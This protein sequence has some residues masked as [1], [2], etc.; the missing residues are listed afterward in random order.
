[1][2]LAVLSPSPTDGSGW[3]RAGG[4]F[5]PL[6]KQHGFQLTTGEM[7]SW[8]KIM[9]CD[10]LFMQRPHDESHFLVAGMARDLKVPIWIDYDDDLTHIPVSNLAHDAYMT[11]KTFRNMKAIIEMAQVAT[12]STPVLQR[13]IGGSQVIPNA[14]NDYVMEMEPFGLPTKIISWRGT[15]SHFADMEP[16][17]PAMKRIAEEIKDWTWVFMGHPHWAF[18]QLPDGRATRYAFDDNLFSYFKRLTAVQPAVHIVTLAKNTFNLS[19]S[20]IAWVEATRAGAVVVAPRLTNRQEMDEWNR[21]GI[22]QYDDPEDFEV[23]LRGLME[24]TDVARRGLV[25][26]S[27][28]YIR[29]N[30]SLSKVNDKR[31]EILK[32]LCPKK[33]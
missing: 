2:N 15:A 33:L 9:A 5:G 14:F 20:A 11:Q 32:N 18:E 13:I 29:D 1:M 31:L 30:L 24:M 19:K 7:W 21:P 25:Q 4:V 22:V 23:K 27:R 16:F 3:Y 28:D 10:A 17:M 8:D 12:V 6:S 26:Q